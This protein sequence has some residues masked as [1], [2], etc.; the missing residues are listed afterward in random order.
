M[1]HDALI[2]DHT[3]CD[4]NYVKRCC[5]Y[6]HYY[7]LGRIPIV[8]GGVGGGGFKTLFYSLKCPDPPWGQSPIQCVPGYFYSWL[9]RTE[10]ET[11]YFYVLQKSRV[12]GTICVPYRGLR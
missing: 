2:V 8:A 4:S 1:C 10:R 3:N 11:D 12:N 9:K 5:R 7:G 6:R